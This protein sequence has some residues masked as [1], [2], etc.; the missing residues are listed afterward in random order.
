VVS[1]AAPLKTNSRLTTENL[2]R[3]LAVASKFYPDQRLPTVTQEALTRYLDAEAQGPL[4]VALGSSRSVRGRGA[5]GRTRRLW[6]HVARPASVEGQ[7]IAD[8]QNIVA[9]GISAELLKMEG[10]AF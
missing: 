1:S 10:I 6:L 2:P 4:L 5:A 3:I 9:K 8:F 7:S